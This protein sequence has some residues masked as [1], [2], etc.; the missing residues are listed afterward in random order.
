[1]LKLLALPSI[2]EFVLFFSKVAS[3]AMFLSVVFSFFPTHLRAE[4]SNPL[5]AF[6]R[7]G[8][9]ADGVG[10][11]ALA[12]DQTV[13]KYA[14]NAENAMI[15]ASTTK[16]MTSLAALDILGP[17]FKWRTHAYLNGKLENGVLAGDLLIVGGGDP[18]LDSAKLTAWFGQLQKRGLKEIAG[19]IIL[20]R[21]RFSLTDKDHAYTPKPDWRNTH[22][23]LPD[24]FVIDEGT[25]SVKIANV[26]DTKIITFEPAFDGIDVVDQTQSIARCANTKKPISVEFDETSSNRKVI[27]TGDWARD[28]AA[29]VV[30]TNPFDMPTFSSGAVLAAWKAAGGTLSGKVVEQA[31]PQPVIKT[32]RPA[33]VAKSKPRKPY[34]TL[35]S[36]QLL[37][38][39]KQ[40]NKWSNNLVS[41]NI[42]LTLSGGFPAIPATL[43]GAQKSIAA[44]L[45]VKGFSD[46]DLYVENG[47]GLSR[48]ERGRPRALAEL[49]RDV[50]FTK[51]DKVFRS[52]LSVAGVDGTMGSRLKRADMAGKALLKTGTLTEVRAVAGYVTAKSGQVYTVVA[53]VNHPNATRAVPAID[54]FVEWVYNNG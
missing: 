11:Y 51:I 32:K 41:R 40:V 39:I 7:A 10:L 44:W 4:P 6:K 36:K 13:P 35:E 43:S 8:V 28:C 48:N 20:D 26:A 14:H 50:S 49:L 24:A 53:L 27:V 29:V 47:S 42:L 23:A 5:D 30:E 2:K 46:A 1:L 21:Q 18:L 38:A 12:L 52:S 54:A 3:T 19:N 16:V 37:D 9:S 31:P 34:A 45:K 15:L 25:L 17:A 33:K 22:H